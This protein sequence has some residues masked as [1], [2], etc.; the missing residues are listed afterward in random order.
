[1]SQT[2]TSLYVYAQ[3]NNHNKPCGTSS[4]LSFFIFIKK[5][6]AESVGKV[7]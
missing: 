6:A 3:Y 5:L 4:G 2:E 1:M 7:E